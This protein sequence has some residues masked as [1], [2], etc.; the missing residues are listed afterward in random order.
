MIRSKY[1]KAERMKLPPHVYALV[2]QTYGQMLTEQKSQSILIS[3]E[4]GAGKTE[5]M[6]IC[7]TFI[8]EL[9]VGGK[10]GGKDQDNVASRLMQTNP[11]MEAIGNA[12]TIRNNNS[13]R[14]GKFFDI[15]FQEDGSILGAFTSIYLL[16]KPRICNHMRGERNYHVFYMLCKSSSD[17]RD[18]VFVKRWETYVI[19]NQDGTVA[20]VTTWDDNAEFKDMHKAFLLLGFSAEQRTELYTMLS[21]CMNLGNVEFV[22]HSSSEGCAVSNKDQLDL[23]CKML[24]VKPDQLAQ[25]LTS[26]TMG[27]GVIEVFVKPLEK[28]QAGQQR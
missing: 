20:E 18:P 15:Q 4:S 12:K 8:G 16:E 2:D 21:V 5:A 1:K 14:F 7:L 3:G 17:V 23:V 13:S 24:Q 26:K 19:N 28:K 10:S 27:G 6:K 22:A 9:A 25:A 11:V